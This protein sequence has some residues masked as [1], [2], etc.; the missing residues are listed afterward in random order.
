MAP[1]PGVIRCTHIVYSPGLLT[2]LTAGWQPIRAQPDHEH[3]AL[4][5]DFRRT[6]LWQQAMA[7]Q[8]IKVL[9]MRLS[10]TEEHAAVECWWAEEG[11]AQFGTG[12]P[13]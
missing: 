3:T 11:H 10:P 8:G 5:E 2:T 6:V 9:A 1:G 13:L 4:M 7:A 12:N